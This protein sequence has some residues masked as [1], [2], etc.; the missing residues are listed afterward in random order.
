MYWP[1]SAKGSVV[2]TTILD[3]DTTA[4]RDV[5]C[6][7]REKDAKVGEGVL[8]KWKVRSHLVSGRLGDTAVCKHA[9]QSMSHRC[10]LGTE[11]YQ[12]FDAGLCA[13][14]FMRNVTIEKKESLQK[15]GLEMEAFF[16]DSQA[17]I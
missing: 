6:W 1:A 2:S 5:Q 11:L 8:M 7:A 3:A 15:H 9:N 13:S 16:G 17:L 12:A 10:N 14:R 4:N